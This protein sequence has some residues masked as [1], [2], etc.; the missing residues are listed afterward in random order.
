MHWSAFYLGNLLVCELN[1]YPRFADGCRSLALVFVSS[2][3][4]H[5][6]QRNTTIRHQ[7]H[8][9]L[10]LQ[11]HE[12]IIKLWNVFHLKLTCI[13]MNWQFLIKNVCIPILID[14]F[15]HLIMWLIFSLLVLHSLE[16]HESQ[17]PQLLKKVHSTIKY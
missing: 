10:H 3:C 14:I 16:C 4:H 8:D 17:K 11:G 9:P 13:L 15:H 7:I 2:L 6:V 12:V 5:K 1:N